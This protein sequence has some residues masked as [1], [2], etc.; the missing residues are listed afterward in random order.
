MG[1]A[2]TRKTTSSQESASVLVE[3]QLGEHLL[4]QDPHDHYAVSRTAVEDDVLALVVTPQARP[5]CITLTPQERLIGQTLAALLELID[6][7]S[8]LIFAPSA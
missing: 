4:V 3:M 7:A 5:Y 1:C 2:S 8:A 6:V